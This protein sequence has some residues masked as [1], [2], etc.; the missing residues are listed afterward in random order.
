MRSRKKY[1][2]FISSTFDDLYRERQ[3]V[4]WALLKARFIPVGMEA[5]SATDDRG[6]KTITATIDDSDYYIL[7]IAGKL[8]T[9]DESTGKS[10]TR[11]EYEYARNRGVPVLA[12]VR[13]QGEIKKDD[14]ERESLRATLLDDF[15]AEVESNHHRERWTDQAD[16]VSRVNTALSNHVQDDEHVGS[17]RPGWYRGDQLP[18]SA[19]TLDELARLSRENANLRSELALRTAERPRL[20]IWYQGRPVTNSL[21]LRCERVRLAEP[22]TRSLSYRAL[23]SISTGPE[24][25]EVV[26]AIN[27][28]IWLEFALRNFGNCSAHS[29]RIEA[30][31]SPATGVQICPASMQIVSIHDRRRDSTAHVY[32]D[33]HGADGDIATIVQRMKDLNPGDTE[34][35]VKFGIEIGDSAAHSHLACR[36]V[37]T[38]AGG[39]LLD[40]NIDI[41]LTYTGRVTTIEESD[42][43]KFDGKSATR[44]AD[45]T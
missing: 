7:I 43:D 29:L 39:P 16:L 22:K 4:T 2:V 6:W 36:F 27:K 15:I 19:E 9:I 33:R 34:Q 42:L 31:V 3:A 38:D 1:Q 5:F 18:A 13:N 45:A 35:L 41:R 8:G 20:E 25:K 21:T 37:V 10:W 23:A 26:N 40:S 14:L 17:D 32:V 11:L 28:T 24:P 44:T 30:A 12:F